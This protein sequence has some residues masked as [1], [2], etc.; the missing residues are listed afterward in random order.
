MPRLL[1]TPP[2]LRLHKA[3]G[4]AVVSINHRDF[5]LGPWQSKASRIEY[6][7]LIG[8]WLAN[9]R[10]LPAEVDSPLSINELIAA[11][12]KFAERYYV[13]DGRPTCLAGIRVALRFLRSSYGNTLVKDFGPL[14]LKAL[15]DRMIEG[16]QSRGYING[17]IGHIRRCFKWGVAQQIVPVVVYQALQTVPG[18]TRT[19]PG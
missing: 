16:G 8:E 12:W 5:Y 18:L 2:K 15:Q 1:N 17:N 14:A 19:R 7:R 11:Y 4:Q 9:N 10:Q 6:D 3:S 13:K